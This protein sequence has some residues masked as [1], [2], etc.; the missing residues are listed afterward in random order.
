MF[1]VKNGHAGKHI[2]TYVIGNYPLHQGRAV[3][4]GG[5]LGAAAP[6]QFALPSGPMNYID[7]LKKNNIDN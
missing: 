2:E 7:A 6:H 5:A 3:I 1:W 4:T